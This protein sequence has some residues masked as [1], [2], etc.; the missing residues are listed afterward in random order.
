M[1]GLRSSTSVGEPPNLAGYYM[2]FHFLFAYAGLSS[3]AL[4]LHYGIDHNVSPREDTAKYGAKAV[5]SGKITQ[6]QLNQLKR[7]ESAHANSVEHYPL[8]V[9][10]MLWANLASLPTSEINATALVYTL[11]RFAYSAVYILA[12]TEKLSRPRGIFWW[13]SNI[14][15]LRLFWL[16]TKAINGRR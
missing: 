8:F 16:G 2:M 9:G 10:A 13:V 12:D 3:R 15:C 7:V 11:A 14:V 4:K 6:K 5:E 1:L